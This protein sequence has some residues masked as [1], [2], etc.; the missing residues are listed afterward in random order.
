MTLTY[1]LLMPSY[2]LNN[3]YITF[4]AYHNVDGMEIIVTLYCL[5]T[6]E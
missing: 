5:W 4:N 1:S 2:T 6:D 3:L